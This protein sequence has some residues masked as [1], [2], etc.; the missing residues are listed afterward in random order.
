MEPGE[1]TLDH[2]CGV[3]IERA[4]QQSAVAQLNDQHKQDMG[5]G[6]VW[7]SLSLADIDQ[8]KV[9]VSLCFHEGVL[10]SLTITLV[11]DGLYGSSWA[12]FAEEKERLRAKHTEEWLRAAGYPTGSF[13]W[14]EIWAGYDSKGGSGYGIIRYKP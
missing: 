5:T 13:S 7:Y 10:D 4:L 6:Y 9:A 1:F 3:R 12:D 2:P 8:K 11:E 14:G